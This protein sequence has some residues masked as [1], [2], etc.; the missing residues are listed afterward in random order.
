MKTKINLIFSLLLISALILL[1]GCEYDVAE[2]LWNQPQAEAPVPEITSITPEGV[3]VAGANTITIEGVNFGSTRDMN[4][5]YFDNVQAEIVTA[6]STEITVRRPNLVVDSCTV[7]VSPHEALV[8]ATY[9]PYG[10]DPVMDYYGNFLENIEL[11]AAVV[12]ANENLYV[13]QRTAP[14]SVVKITPDQEREILNA[15][16]DRA[17]TDAVI[18][19]DGMMVLLSNNRDMTKLNLETG[20]ETEWLNLSKSVSYGDFDSNGNLYAGGRRSDL[21]V[22]LSDETSSQAGFWA[23]DEILWVRVFG[24]YV[25][26]LVDIATPTDELPD[27]SIWCHAIDGAGAVGEAELV[28]NWTETGEY[29]E[30]LPHTFVFSADGKMLVGTDYVHPIMLFDLAT[31]AQDILYKEI[32][33]TSALKLVWGSG[34][35]VYMILGGEVFDMVRIDMGTAGA[36]YFGR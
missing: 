9:D 27:M 15:E 12:D 16:V 7:K 19:P 36:P 28:V 25:Y 22:V 20:E 3:A 11:T 14:V 17:E 13:F 26:V 32:L 30:S 2:P 10:I 6:S 5:V 24:D 4:D 29:A 34:T 33:P 23:R 1:A 31:G 21:F 18:G 35:N 8:F